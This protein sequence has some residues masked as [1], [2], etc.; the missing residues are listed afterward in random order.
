MVDLSI[1]LGDIEALVQDDI[2]VH[3]QWYDRDG[4]FLLQGWLEPRGE[5]VQ[6]DPYSFKRIYDYATYKQAGGQYDNSA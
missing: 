3:Y 5:V 2:L 6:F 4:E 1:S